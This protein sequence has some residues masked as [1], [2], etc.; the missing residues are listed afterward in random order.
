MKRKLLGSACTAAL[1]MSAASQAQ[2]VFQ[3][4]GANWDDPDHSVGENES[5]RS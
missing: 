2:I 4:A 5:K 1:A 3:G